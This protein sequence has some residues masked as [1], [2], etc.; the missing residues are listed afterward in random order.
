MERG[1]RGEYIQPL[2]VRLPAGKMGNIDNLLKPQNPGHCREKQANM[3]TALRAHDD[4]V[5]PRQKSISEGKTQPR[6][7]KTAINPKAVDGSPDNHVSVIEWR[8]GQSFGGWWL[9]TQ[10]TALIPIRL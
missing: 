3:T 10:L 1:W 9:S 7:Q 8:I 2:F 4:F 6:P 5:M